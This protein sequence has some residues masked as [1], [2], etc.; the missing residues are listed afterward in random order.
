M[1]TQISYT[2]QQR[3]STRIKK[4]STLKKI[5]KRAAKTKEQRLKEIDKLVKQLSGGLKLDKHLTPDE[6]NELFEQS[7]EE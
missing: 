1:S 5:V 7:Y 4:K 3:I 6:L 2:D